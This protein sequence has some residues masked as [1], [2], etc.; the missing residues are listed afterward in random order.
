MA[1]TKITQEMLD[2]ILR[3]RAEFG[4]S[5]SQCTRYAL[6]KY[7]VEISRTRIYQRINKSY[8]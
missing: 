5:L 2:E 7:G 3:V 4:L 1:E 6:N 8:N